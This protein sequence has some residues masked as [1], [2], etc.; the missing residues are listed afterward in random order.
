DGFQGSIKI[1]T[2]FIIVA[3]ALMFLCVVV[4]PYLQ[5]YIY[6]PFFHSYLDLGVL[7][8]AFV[9]LVVV[10]AANAVN[11]TDGLDGL[12]SVPVIINLIC[13]ILVIFA[14]FSAGFTAG[15]AQLIV[16]CFILIGAVG[17][18]L[19]FN[20]KPAK[21]F[22][23]DVGSLSIGA[24]LGMIAVMIRQELFFALIGMLFVMEAMSVILQVSSYKLFK[25]RIFLMS[26][27]H[28]HFEKMGWGEKKVVRI[29]WLAALIFAIIGLSGIFNIDYIL[30]KLGYIS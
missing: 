23:G 29:F 16:F 6:I 19:I 22:M 4:K 7:Y 25:K 20:R 17:A 15:I 18:F 21:I 24:V 26:P 28:H 10:G 3:I 27:I 5:N 30:Y 13:F 14:L 8:A 12:V 9:L 2:Q 11:L 1:V